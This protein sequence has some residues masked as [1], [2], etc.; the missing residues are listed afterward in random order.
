MPITRMRTIPPSRAMVCDILRYDRKVPTCAHD[1]Y[2]D[3]N[4]V[5]AARDSA[6]IRVSWPAIFMKAYV[7]NAARFPRLRQTW[8]GW[9]WP[10]LYEHPKHVGT[11]VMHRV[12]ENDDWLFWVRLND[13]GQRS[14]VEITQEIQRNQTEPA[15]RLFKRQV[16]M[17]KLPSPL[18]RICWWMTFQ[19]SGSKKCKR[20]GTFFLTTISGKGAEIQ[21]P[22]SILTS[23]FTYGP[24]DEHGKCRVTISYDHR[25]MDGHHVADILAGFE[26]SMRGEMLAELRTLTQSQA[27]A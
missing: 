18:R 25:L 7:I 8:M 23:G 14:L 20:L 16:W 15:D 26:Q 5:V 22:P 19:L 10:H 21:E 27:A 1:R 17:A 3:L 24:I 9:P 6:R 4:E 13:L 12:F 2:F 11:L